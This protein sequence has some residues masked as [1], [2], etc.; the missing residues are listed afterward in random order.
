M[1]H[2]VLDSTV[3]RQDPERTR[4][5]FQTLGKLCEQHALA[6]HIPSIVR[7][8]FI[9]HRADMAERTLET[10][11]RSVKELQ[12]ISDPAEAKAVVD[13]VLADLN[14]LTGSYAADIESRFDEWANANGASIEDVPADCLN[15]VLDQY[16]NG[17]GPFKKIK[18]REDFPDAFIWHTIR[19][20]ASH[21]KLYVVSGDN[22][23]RKAVAEI[24]NVEVF[25]DLDALIES[26]TIQQLFPDNFV[27]KNSNAILGLIEEHKQYL[28]DELLGWLSAELTSLHLNYRDDESSDIVD[29]SDIT[30]VEFDFF[31]AGQY[32]PE[33]LRI[34]FEATVEA[35]VDHLLLKTTYY[36]MP[37]SESDA[38][39]IEDP[40][41]NEYYLH[42]TEEVELEVTGVL[43][44][45][46]DARAVI[47]A[48]KD[49]ALTWDALQYNCH[50]SL[51]RLDKPK[52]KDAY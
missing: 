18:N 38:L 50:I 17:Q 16:F 52:I 22:N 51:D 48:L 24:A 27:R 19:Q 23:L 4:S 1:L 8:E 7:R 37:E 3:F 14:N 45:E 42:V 13:R 40:D 36:E 34:P 41:W 35:T 49:E 21:H 2:V 11:I 39:S 28:E 26:E 12:R 33:T 31:R 30:T 20:L 25:D 5:G 44:I 43:A 15:D 32:G 29:V 10:T 46:T 6:L 9:S 47:A